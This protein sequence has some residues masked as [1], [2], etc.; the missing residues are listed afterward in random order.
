MIPNGY[1]KNGVLLTLPWDAAHLLVSRSVGNF[2]CLGDNERGIGVAVEGRRISNYSF[3]DGIPTLTLD[4]GG[5]VVTR[6]ESDQL[7]ARR[8]DTDELFDEP[9][10][11]NLLDMWPDEPEVTP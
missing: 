4:P 6:G 2:D 8:L 1:R 11:T 3:D 5:F 9:P 10:P 7:V